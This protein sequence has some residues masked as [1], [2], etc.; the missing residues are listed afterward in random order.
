M[1]AVTES[2]TCGRTMGEGEGEGCSR[3]VGEGNRRTGEKGQKA[4]GHVW[5]DP[6]EETVI[7]CAVCNGRANGFHYGADTCAACK[8]LVF[9]HFK[10]TFW[11][12]TT[13][14][15]PLAFFFHFYSSLEHTCVSNLC[16]LT[17]RVHSTTVWYCFHRCLSVHRGRGYPT[18]PTP[19]P[20]QAKVPTPQPGPDGG[21]GTP[22]YLPPTKVPTPPPPG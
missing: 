9:V 2:N 13:F 7:P 17:D 21:R 19:P 14:R 18:V 8:V 6:L 15:V 4:T 11:L 1:E 20:P 5:F 3:A 12:M 10:C 22:R 16:I